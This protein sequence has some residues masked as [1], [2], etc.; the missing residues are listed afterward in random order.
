MQIRDLGKATSLRLVRLLLASGIMIA[1][2][3]GFV[4]SEAYVRSSQISVMENIL[5]P[6][7]DVK[8]SGY[9]HPDFLWTR[10]SWWIEIESS[11][12]VVLRLDEWEGTIE[13]GN[14]RV[15]SNHDDMNTN[16]FSEK[17]FWGYPSEVSVEKV[18]SRK[19]L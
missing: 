7:S 17:S 13:E 15:F 8:A 4:F 18:K 19:S 16:E 11:H 3:I 2:F 14:H 10:R 9:W 12:P 1:L 5:N 6:Y